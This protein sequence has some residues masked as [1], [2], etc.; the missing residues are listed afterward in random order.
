V[1]LANGPPQAVG[2]AL[3]TVIIEPDDKRVL[4][5]WRGHLGLRAGPHDVK[6]VIAEA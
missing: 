4:L 1:T 2:M 6:E 5:L 3:D